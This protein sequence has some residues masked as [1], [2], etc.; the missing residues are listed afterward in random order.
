[1]ILTVLLLSMTLFAGG[2]RVASMG[3]VFSLIETTNYDV[4]PQRLL[5][6]G[7]MFAIGNKGNGWGLVRLKLNNFLDLPIPMAWQI[8]AIR[9]NQQ[10][11]GGLFGQVNMP[12]YLSVPEDAFD[13]ASQRINSIF[14]FQIHIACT[15]PTPFNQILS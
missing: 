5:T 9:G 10:T 12:N 13:T 6:G 8:K 2:T 14:A 15:S 7:E 3:S 1:M 4:F 11:V